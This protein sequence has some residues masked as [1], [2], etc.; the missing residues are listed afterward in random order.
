MEHGD[1][2]PAVVK[3]EE[4]WRTELGEERY[5]VLRRAGTERPFTGALLDVDAEGAYRCG[6]CGAALFSSEAKFESHCGWPSFTHPEQ[7]ENVRLVDDDSLG[8]HR[9]E[10]RCKRCDSHLGHVFE[11]G[12]GPRNTRYCI[13]SLALNFTPEQ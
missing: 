8:V 12:P 4:Q 7:Q 11:D 1:A 9:I 3:P 5:R 2:N 6:A 10:V 13:N